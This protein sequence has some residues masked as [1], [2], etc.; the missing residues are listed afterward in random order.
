MKFN[1]ALVKVSD[2][3]VIGV[4]V[5]EEDFLEQPMETRIA[6]M[7]QYKEGFGPHVPIVLLLEA[8]TSS[9]KEIFWGRPDLTEQLKEI[10]LN[11][12]TF[13]TFEAPDDL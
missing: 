10:P 2:E 13:K 1:G 5:V 3:Q 6:R 8:A 11:M 12:M 4:A 9:S 7:K